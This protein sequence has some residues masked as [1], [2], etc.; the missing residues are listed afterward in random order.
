[1]TIR[2]TRKVRELLVELDVAMQK[3]HQE[4]GRLASKNISDTE[5]M[6]LGADREHTRAII[7]GIAYRINKASRGERS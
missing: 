1:M 6:N 5:A 2:C 3:F 7:V 4:T